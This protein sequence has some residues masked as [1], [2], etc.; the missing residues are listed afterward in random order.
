MIWPLVNPLSLLLSLWAFYE[1]KNQDMLVFMGLNEAGAGGEN[2]TR[3]ISLEGWSN[4]IIRHPRGQH[5][6][7]LG[8]FVKSQG[9]ALA[10]FPLVDEGIDYELEL[11]GLFENFSLAQIARALFEDAV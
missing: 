5:R 9:V 2:R 1:A 6:S 11:T 10:G 8:G 3:V 4:T 7:G